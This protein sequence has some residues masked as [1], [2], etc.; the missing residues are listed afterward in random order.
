LSELL[1]IVASA[2]GA[3]SLVWATSE[4]REYAVRRRRHGAPR[5]PGYVRMRIALYAGLT[6]VGALL[7]L[8]LAAWLRR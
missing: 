6:T 4:V 2:A 3:L 5:A 8:A 1:A 7:G